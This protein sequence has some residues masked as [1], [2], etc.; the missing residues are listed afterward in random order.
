MSVADQV[1]AFAEAEIVVATH[2]AALAN[3]A[4]TSPG[5]RVIE[6]FAPD[7]VAPCFW[8]LAQRVPGLRYR[9][10]VAEGTRRPA[11]V[12]AQMGLTSDL[13]VNVATLLGLLDA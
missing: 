11:R 7:L 10:L 3:L 2:G 13:T 12:R 9:Y 8:A 5:A 1:K 6:I 4:F